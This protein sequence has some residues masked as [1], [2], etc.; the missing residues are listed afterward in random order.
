MDLEKWSPFFDMAWPFDRFDRTGK[1][2]PMMDL[3]VT[4]DDYILTA[5][6]PG[7]SPEDVDV[8][9]EGDVLTISGEKRDERE[10]D[11]DDHYLHERVFGSFLRRI[12]VPAGVSDDDIKAEFE[13]GVLTVK[14]E[15][16]E[17][18]KLETKRIPVTATS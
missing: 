11:E 14:V 2:R 16:P 9:L 5:E 3:V 12:T 17:E 15:L 10:V 4:D 8:S 7:I 6:L 13:N 1:M 18:K